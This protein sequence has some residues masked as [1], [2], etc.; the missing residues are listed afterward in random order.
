MIPNQ[1]RLT[2]AIA[3]ACNLAL[4]APASVRAANHSAER[5]Q[6]ATPIKHVI[7]IFNENI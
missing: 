7:V 1:A 6:T 3:L 4:V 5:A 2:A